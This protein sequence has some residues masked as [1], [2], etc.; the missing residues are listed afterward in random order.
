MVL[1]FNVDLAVIYSLLRF[2]IAIIRQF[3][4]KLATETCVSLIKSRS[5]YAAVI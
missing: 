2:M 1:A 5:H 4:L 3:I